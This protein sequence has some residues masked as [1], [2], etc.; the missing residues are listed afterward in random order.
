MAY[1]CDILD[2]MESVPQQSAPGDLRALA[3]AAARLANA[4]VVQEEIPKQMPEDAEK[5]LVTS[6]DNI[7][8]NLEDPPQEATTGNLLTL[9]AVAARLSRVSVE[10]ERMRKQVP[11]ERLQCQPQ[12]GLPK[13]KAALPQDLMF[14]VPTNCRAGQP[15]CVQGP[16]GPLTIPLPQGYEQGEQCSYRFGPSALHRIGVSV[17]AGHKCGDVVKFEG[18][19]GETLEAV[20]PAGKEVGDV[21]EV[22]PPVM[23][24]Q[25]PPGTQSGDKVAFSAPD[26][27]ERCVVIPQGR[28]ADQYFPAKL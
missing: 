4:S 2:N 5:S 9:A 24:I 28:K 3:T 1:T 14:T 26:G 16:H 19:D 20:V 22:M 12:S 21:F 10:P 15:V 8:D 7:L 25:V 13:A 11:E 18:P 17:P 6:T 27:T 23:M